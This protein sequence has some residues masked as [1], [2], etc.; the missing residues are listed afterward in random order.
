MFLVFV[1]LCPELQGWATSEHRANVAARCTP[2]LEAMGGLGWK[3][4]NQSK[5]QA[6]TPYGPGSPETTTE[7]GPLFLIT[8]TST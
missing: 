5:W 4:V 2:P 3:G 6:N 7:H 8:Q 1:P